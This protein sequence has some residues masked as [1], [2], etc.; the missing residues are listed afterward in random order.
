MVLKVARVMAYAVSRRPVTTEACVRTRGFYGGQC[1]TGM[2]FSLR[3]PIV[4]IIPYSYSS[5]CCFYEDIRLPKAIFFRKRRAL[6]RNV[7]SFFSVLQVLG[8]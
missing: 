3:T 7:L 4:L 1:G 6:D 2:G 8:S 5:V